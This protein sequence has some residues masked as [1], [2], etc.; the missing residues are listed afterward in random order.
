M[1]I[2][3][4]SAQIC[5]FPYDLVCK[6]LRRFPNQSLEVVW[7]QEEPQN[8]GAWSYAQPRLSNCLRQF[9]HTKEIAVRCAVCVCVIM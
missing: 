2:V 6:E 3:F 4:V 5:P 1:H 9:D 7:A 8:M